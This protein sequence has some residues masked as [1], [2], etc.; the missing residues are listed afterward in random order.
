MAIP[1]LN[2]ART[3]WGKATWPQWR[4]ALRNTLAMCM[5]LAIAYGLDLD[6]PYWAMTSAAVVSFPTVG[7]VI[8]KSFGRIAGSFLGATAA[9]IIAG[10]TLNDPWVFL[11]AMA[12]WLAVCT[13]VSSQYQNNVSYAFAL[14]G[15]TASI[16]AF[17]G[18]N[19]D[20][21]SQIWVLAQ[22]RVCEV[23][24]GILCS[25]FMMMVLPSASD[26][27]ALISSLNTLHARLLEHATL[28]WRQETTESI[29]A[30][31]EAV[32]SQILTMNLLRIQAFW[33]HYRFRQHNAL[34]NYLLHQQLRLTSVTSGLR[35]MLLNWPDPPARLWPLLDQLLAELGRPDT[36]KYQL[37]RLLAEHLPAA[38]DD[39]RCRAFRER[40]RYFCWAYLDSSRWL[41]HL[42]AAPLHD[43]LRAPRAR[44]LSRHTDNVEATWGALRTFVVIT[45]TGAWCIGTQWSSAPAALTLAAICC[46]L[47]STSSTPLNSVTLLLRTLLLLSLFAFGVKFG[48][49]VQITELWQ[50]LLFLFVVV[51]TMQLLRQQMPRYT[52][53]WAQLIVFMGSFISVS[54][55]PVYDY[56]TFLNDILAKILGVGMTWIAYSVLAPGSDR[57]RGERHIRA[58]RAGF[59]D[60][61]SRLPR[62]SEQQFES[63]VYHHVSQLSSS[64]DDETRRWVLRWGAVLLNCSHVVW[65]LRHQPVKNDPLGIVQENCITLLRDVMSQQ[66]VRQRPL[67]SALDELQ[68]I[69]A[70]LARHHSPAAR[71]LAGVIWRLY[72]A[73]QQLT[74]ALPEPRT[75]ENRPP[76]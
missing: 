41:R 69:S 14:A 20:D 22:A 35:R 2:W 55:P 1:T 9:L 68:R 24:V 16:I 6:D 43:D 66:G 42:E 63:L 15:I 72:C 53:L 17:P 73:L 40:L 56:G 28:L 3:P 51:V 4:Y 65:Q 57:R 39:Y 11:L 47:Y 38:Q 8:S 44:S 5:A 32:I 59:V 26:G 74:L 54:N 19:L 58:L 67:T 49:M 27:N 12:A 37:A 13:W 46:V 23:I 64:K 60:Q 34:L 76:Q 61:L 31:H 25:G 52:S 75:A 7:G 48:L 10:H 45:L 21:I 29:R 36:S 30:A 71:D 50:F 70:S 18:V 62:N 33:S